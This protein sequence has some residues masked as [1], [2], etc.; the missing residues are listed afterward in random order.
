MN[1]QQLIEMGLGEL[2]IEGILACHQAEMQQQSEAAQEWREK[3]EELLRQS[4]EGERQRATERAVGALR[5]SSKGARSAFLQALSK[6]EIPVGEA[7]LD[8]V[9]YGEFLAQY[10]AEDPE[11]FVSGDTPRFV[12]ATPGAGMPAENAH[13]RANEALRAML[14]R[15]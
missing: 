8:P 3:Y 10:Q 2:E 4:A 15:D 12:A 14:R 9:L 7:G 11:A 1:Q 13:A 6:H 5:F